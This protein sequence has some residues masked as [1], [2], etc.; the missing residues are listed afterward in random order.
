MDQS[1]L[2]VRIVTLAIQID[3]LQDRSTKAI[4]TASQ[5]D[6]LPLDI[7]SLQAYQADL[8]LIHEMDIVTVPRYLRDCRR[9]RRQD[10]IVDQDI[11]DLLL[12]IVRQS[13]HMIHFIDH[14]DLMT[15]PAC[16]IGMKDLTDV[17]MN[18]DTAMMIVDTQRETHAVK[19]TPGQ[20]ASHLE[21]PIEKFVCQK[22]TMV[23]FNLRLIANVL[24]WLK[25]MIVVLL[26]QLQVEQYQ[27]NLQ[28]LV[29][30]RK[31]QHSSIT[32]KED[33]IFL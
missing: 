24:I 3:D 8:S 12:R 30:I 22:E 1:L 9:M 31:E 7:H 14:Q 6:C 5:E 29:S 15:D 27:P 25:S 23:D 18:L 10:Q 16:W 4:R 33:L 32:L 19:E 21:L 2:L 28:Q 17:N 26:H 13:L 20:N 11:N